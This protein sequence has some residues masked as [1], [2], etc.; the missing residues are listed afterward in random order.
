MAMMIQITIR[1]N[2]KIMAYLENPNLAKYPE[3]GK[4]GHDDPDHGQVKKKIRS[5]LI[6]PNFAEYPELAKIAIKVKITKRL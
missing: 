3:L 4:D 6:D 2:K 5:H 1:S